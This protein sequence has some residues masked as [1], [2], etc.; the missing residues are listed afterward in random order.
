MNLKFLK[1]VYI[2]FWWFLNVCLLN[3][4]LIYYWCI[5]YCLNELLIILWCIEDYI[6][7]L[8]KIFVLMNNLVNIV[9]FSKKKK[10]IKNILYEK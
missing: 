1:W 9:E 5:I 10:F 6:L 3:W 8:K 7:K 4:Y 2:K